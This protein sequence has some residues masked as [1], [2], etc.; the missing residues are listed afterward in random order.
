MVYLWQCMAAAVV[1]AGI[2]E[3]TAEGTAAA[4]TAAGVGKKD[5]HVHVNIAD[6]AAVVNIRDTTRVYHF[7]RQVYFDHQPCQQQQ[8][9]SYS[10]PSQAR[11]ESVPGA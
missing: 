9:V 3:G 2:A 6:V 8:R 10:W 7:H 5:G 1:V 11:I 4:D